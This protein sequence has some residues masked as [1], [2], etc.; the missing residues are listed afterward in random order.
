[1]KNKN[2]KVV[3][4]ITSFISDVIYHF[5]YHFCRAWPILSKL[6]PTNWQ[7]ISSLLS[8]CRFHKNE[9]YFVLK[10]WHLLGI[11]EYLC[12]HS[13]KKVKSRA[14][15]N[16]LESFK[17]SEVIDTHKSSNC[18]MPMIRSNIPGFRC[19]DSGKS[20]FVWWFEYIIAKVSVKDF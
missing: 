3:K 4:F 5:L 16:K 12:N 14:K 1:M 6:L 7:R 18:V 10:T 13:K 20:S 2:H 8:H 9:K 15:I 17:E 11:I 19:I